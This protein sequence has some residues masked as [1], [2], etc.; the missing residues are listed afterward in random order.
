M[1]NRITPAA[2][3]L[4]TV[5]QCQ[6]FIQAKGLCHTHY[7]AAKR[8]DKNGAKPIK[9]RVNDG[10]CKIVDCN[11][12]AKARGLCTQHYEDDC[13]TTPAVR[14]VE[15]RVLNAGKPCTRPGCD[16]LAKTK[17]LCNM[18]YTRTRRGIPIDAPEQKRNV[19]NGC[20]VI[21]CELPA[22]V[23]G[24]CRRH[25]QRLRSAVSMDAPWRLNY[26]PG[27]VCSLS[28]CDKRPSDNGYC[29]SHAQTFRFY[30]ASAFD[31]LER[32][33]MSGCD[34]CGDKTILSEKGHLLWRIDHDH[35]CCKGKRTCGNCI[36]GVLCHSCN[37]G[38]GLLKDSVYVMTRAISYLTRGTV[39]EQRREA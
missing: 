11:K 6:H 9:Q 20:E 21:S 12:A 34:I 15:K 17:T 5:D 39:E 23:K 3:Q 36:R 25:F 1:S 30:G 10:P 22:T 28:G 33:M 19:G 27:A 16:R 4:C 7:A 24:M 31:H 37:A 8:L 2:L 35:S 13:K 26:A 29:K 18:H 38:I 32:F 14:R